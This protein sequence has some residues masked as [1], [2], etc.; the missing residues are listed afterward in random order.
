MISD[1]TLISGQDLAKMEVAMNE[2]GREALTQEGKNKEYEFAL[3]MIHYIMDCGYKLPS[4]DPE[5]MAAVWAGQLEEAII[6]YG[7]DDIARVVKVWA[8]EDDREFKQF[9]TTGT[10]IAKIKEL[11][12]NPV[13]EI[14]RRNHEAMVEQMVAAEKQ[15]LMKDVSEEHLKELQRRYQ[16]EQS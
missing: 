14:A 12:G 10:I 3:R 13:A 15:E 7:Y 5:G 1:L 4:I 16:N 6:I 11:L 8:K 9:P 2:R